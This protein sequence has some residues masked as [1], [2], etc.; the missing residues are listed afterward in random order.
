MRGKGNVYIDD[1]ALTMT[2]LDTLHRQWAML[3]HIPSYPGKID[4]GTLRRKL[5]VEGYL[6]SVRTIQRD[7]KMLSMVFPLL[8]DGRSRPYGW[9]W[10]KDAKVYPTVA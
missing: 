9:S 2:K 7:L 5:E 6:V 10:E 1:P 8:E 3:R 4:T